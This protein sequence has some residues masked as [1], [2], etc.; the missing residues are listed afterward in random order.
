MSTAIYVALKLFKIVDTE[1]D[2]LH[3]CNFIALDSIAL[4]VGFLGWVQLKKTKS[5]TDS[6]DDGG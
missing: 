4:A 1:D 3:I 5:H 6:T 2:L